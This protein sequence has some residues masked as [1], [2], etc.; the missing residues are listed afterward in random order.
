ME[1]V[2]KNFRCYEKASFRFN[3]GFTL[4]SGESGKGKTT[5]FMAILFALY[6]KG[7]KVVTFGKKSCSVKLVFGDITIIRSKSP[8]KLCVN[9][10]YEGDVA[11]SI[12]DAKFGNQTFESVSY[13]P[14]FPTNSFILLTP[15]QK[16]QFLEQFAFKNVNLT[17]IKESLKS[18]TKK[19]E[20]LML[21]AKSKI[22]V[23]KQVLNE[24]ELDSKADYEDISDVSIVELQT[25]QEE[26]KK[27]IQDLLSQIDST[28]RTIKTFTEARGRVKSYK[29][30]K[31]FLGTSRLE[32]EAELA[33]VKETLTSVSYKGDE[34]LTEVKKKLRIISDNQKYLQLRTK[35]DDKQVTLQKIREKEEKNLKKEIEVLEGNIITQ[36]EKKEILEQVETLRVIVDCMR[37]V[38]DLKVQ[39][40]TVDL[41]RLESLK[42]RVQKKKE[43]IKSKVELY[44]LL[45]IQKRRYKCPSCEIELRFED[46]DLYI[47]TDKLLCTKGDRD[48][49]KLE[50]EIQNLNSEL[51]DLEYQ[52]FTDTDKIDRNCYIEAKII[53]QEKVLEDYEIDETTLLEDLAEDLTV[54]KTTLA[55]DE[56]NRI[57]ISVLKEKIKHKWFSESCKTLTEEICDIEAKVNSYTV[58]DLP[59]EEEEDLKKELIKQVQFQKESAL[60][61][62]RIHKLTNWL[63]GNK[64]QLSDVEDLLDQEKV[65][66]VNEIDRHIE[67]KEDEVDRIEAILQQKRHL[68]EKLDKQISYKTEENKYKKWNEKLLKLV[69]EESH[70]SSEHV[71]CLL[72]KKNVAEAESVVVLEI[73]KSLNKHTQFYLDI[74]FKETPMTI[75]ISP[76]KIVRKVKKPQIDIVLYYK[77]MECQINMLSGGE[78]SRVILAFTLALGDIFNNS[79]LL[80]DECTANLN[81]SLTNEVFQCVKN[82]SNAKCILAIGH[83]VVKGEFDNIVNV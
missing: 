44:N 78:M 9:D 23:T 37:K 34:F 15:T 73:V 79:F 64:Q 53:E 41:D 11:Q 77:G 58:V 14:Q 7:T 42:E 60:Y 33:E 29:T 45:E 18:H 31:E 28:K 54:Y 49:N 10:K 30:Q 80:L 22:E 61:T 43:E 59:K 1:L 12:I 69:A 71:L 52:V 82:H 5:L 4:I 32:K 6:N 68:T 3:N 39:L 55:E 8:N 46:N 57:R 62:R 83:Q 2:L 35:L 17:K 40:H 65:S 56:E 25:R 16:L 38:E 21:E 20:T 13:L 76:F 26:N 48:L 51:D 67:S 74:F 72:L 19:T 36:E 24:I 66:C 81:E 75:N 27:S 50:K 70:Y 63:V 47:C